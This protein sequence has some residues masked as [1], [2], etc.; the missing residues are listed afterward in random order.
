MFQP[1]FPKGRSIAELARVRPEPDGQRQALQAQYT[2]FFPGD[3]GW[4]NISTYGLGFAGYHRPKH[5]PRRRGGCDIHQSSR[6][7][8]LH[9]RPSGNDRSGVSRVARESVRGL[10]LT[11][12]LALCRYPRCA[13]APRR[14]GRERT[15]FYHVVQA[16]AESPRRGFTVYIHRETKPKR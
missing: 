6:P 16:E 10:L 12:G 2:G 3:L 9:G 1:R 13:G 4:G 5:R 15:V 7:A 14:E 11:G 8:V